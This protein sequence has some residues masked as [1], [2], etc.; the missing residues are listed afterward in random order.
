MPLNIG[1]FALVLRASTG[2]ECNPHKNEFH[3]LSPS[4]IYAIILDP[5]SRNRHALSAQT[6]PNQKAPQSWLPRSYANQQGSRHLKSQ[7]SNWPQ[8]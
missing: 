4:Q 8:D 5:P 3:Q 7:A 1:D 2:K 6:Q